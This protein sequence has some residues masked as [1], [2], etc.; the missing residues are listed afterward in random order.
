MKSL[1]GMISTDRASSIIN[2]LREQVNIFI[3]LPL[4]KWY[5]QRVDGILLWFIWRLQNQKFF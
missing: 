4:I 2:E 5:S 1:P 3:A